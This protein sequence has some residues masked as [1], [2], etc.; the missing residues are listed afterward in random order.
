MVW[1]SMSEPPTPRRPVWMAV[2]T[3]AMLIYAGMSLVDALSL[4]RRPQAPTAAAIEDV[5]R[6]SGQIEAARRLA[7][8]SD[9]VVAAHP[10]AV[11]IEAVAAALVALLTLFA[12]A[13]IF[14]RDRRARRAT[15]AAGWAG[16]AYQ[17]GALPFGV[18]MARRAAEAGAPVLHQVLAQSG[19]D[20]HNLAERDVAAALRGAVVMMPVLRAAMGMA[21]SL[22]LLIFFG[23]RRGR[24]VFGQDS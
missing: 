9:A 21:W 16:I 12:V 23:G 13:A 1:G 18:A 20:F 4:L 14:S 2:M 24:A 7:A 11:R 22:A 19:R 10:A 6:A 15:V 17:L 8:V 3:S 5:A